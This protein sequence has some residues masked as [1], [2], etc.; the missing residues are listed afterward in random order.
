MKLSIK[1][2]K[3]SIGTLFGHIGDKISKN[4]EKITLSFKGA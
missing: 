4:R 1:L 2:K 3:D